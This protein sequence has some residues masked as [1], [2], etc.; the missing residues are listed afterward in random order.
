MISDWQGIVKGVFYL[1]H[2]SLRIP[3]I[4]LF[5]PWGDWPVDKKTM[6]RHGRWLGPWSLFL[7]AAVVVDEATGLDDFLFILGHGG[8]VEFNF[9]NAFPHNVGFD[10]FHVAV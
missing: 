10:V 9:S 1:V 6:D 5:S 2:I 3:S 4:F 7:S 8:D